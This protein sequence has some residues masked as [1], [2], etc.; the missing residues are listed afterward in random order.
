MSRKLTAYLMAVLMLLP[1][2]FPA[3]AKNEKKPAQTQEDSVARLVRADTLQ[4]I[5]IR[6][7]NYRKVKG[8]AV[9][10][11]NN[12]YL[13][14]DSALW[15]VETK[16]I[17]AMG[18]VKLKQERTVLTSERLT[19]YVDK[20]LAEFR[21][22]V[23]QLV[24]K[25]NNTLRTRYLDYNTK[26]SV[27]VFR[28]GGAMRD[29]DGQ[30]IESRT[31]TYDSKTKCFTF[32]DDVNMFSDTLFVKTS[33]LKYDSDPNTATFGYNT[34]AWKDD[35]MLAANAGWY[36]RNRELFFFTKQVH[37]MSESQEAWSDSLYFNRATNDVRMLGHAQVTDTT[38][39]V[40]AL[41]GLIDYVDSIGRTIL[42][43]DPAIIS[44]T[45]EKDQYGET[46]KDSLYFGADSIVY[47]SIRMCDVDSVEKVDAK[48]RLESVD[49][50]PV[51]SH[52]KQ[53]AE[54]A[55][56]AA[57]EAAANDP[58][59]P[60]N[61]KKRAEE[62]AAAKAA[63]AEKANTVLESP[64]S[65][66][67]NKDKQEEAP[68]A[69]ADSTAVTP[70]PADSPAVPSVSDT[71][72]TPPAEP[73]PE[74][75]DSLITPSSE[76][77]DTPPALD[78]LS[79]P[80]Q[81]ET[82]SDTLSTVS[83][84]VAVA[85]TLA[86]KEPL[87]TTKVGFVHAYRNVR[88]FRKSMQM[89]CDSLSYNDLDSLARL[90]ESP[91]VWNEEGRHQYSAD[92][93][94]AVVH[95][96]RMEKANLLNNAFIH[97]QEDT[98]HYD[99]I[100]STEM[101]AFFAEDNSL[102]RF[103]A[104]GGTTAL[105]YLEENHTLATVNRKECKMMSAVFKDGE[106][107]KIYYF[108][109]AKSDGY[110]VVQMSQ[111]DQHLKGFSWTPDRRP[112]SRTDVTPLNL[113]PSERSRYSAVTRPKF[114]QTDIYFPGYISDIH[115]QIEVRDS[116]NKINAIRREEMKAERERLAEIARQD[117][118]RLAADSIKLAIADSLATVDSL[119][120]ADSLAAAVADSIASVLPAVPDAVDTTSVA[121]AEPK[122]PT[123]EE[124]EAQ[125]KAEKEAAKKA[126]AEEKARKK[127]EKQ[128]ALEKKW[129]EQDA[130]AAAKAQAKK[131]KKAEKLRKKKEKTLKAQMRQDEIDQ[132]KLEAYIERYQKKLE[133]QNRK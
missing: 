79:T 33:Y 53:A 22:G 115:K 1:L 103:D 90:Y 29:K 130:K 5:E 18:H 114:V 17:D 15:N 132:A 101:T 127:A 16:V 83:D 74:T 89:V 112:K 123:K 102:S 47:S 65:R 20:D 58:N 34:N 43:R 122:V 129:A 118:L 57:E 73:A 92:S 104:L 120:K 70:P 4:L 88:M 82:L 110:P 10:F 24:D 21:G 46:V 8:N 32:T 28:N 27:A 67:K 3:R 94:Y 31:G 113:R 61:A 72:S 54:A 56:K 39:N 44:E 38:R 63:A 66:K 26:D 37:V 55:R 131:D 97:I 42:T 14:C 93:I 9:F 126:K 7:V 30:V 111:E 11:H 81:L 62:A 119:A 6:H 12:T 125:A 36:D 23:V 60:E 109:T 80:T 108:E 77:L 76:S 100:K 49:T 96:N 121:P 41:A 99:Q 50:D 86:P 87:D 116:L 78:T 51:S 85:D 25:D 52:R 107:N 133:K 35:N 106:I 84:S 117:S 59:N 13:I 95:N 105:F 98:L 64:R 2:F 19:Y 69:A 68:A 124:L 48:K 40:F 75:I 91:V 71:L 45:E 128:A